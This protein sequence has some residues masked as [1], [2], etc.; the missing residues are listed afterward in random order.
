MRNSISGLPERLFARTLCAV[1]VVGSISLANIACGT[2]RIS[3]TY[4]AHGPYFASMLQLTETENGQITGVV[5]SVELKAD[6]RLNSGQASIT[7]GAADADQ[8]TLTVHSFLFG[9]NVS[10]SGIKREKPMELS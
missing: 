2:S 4:V 10:D 1:L 8:V 6:G 3:G 9:T 7:G 5:A